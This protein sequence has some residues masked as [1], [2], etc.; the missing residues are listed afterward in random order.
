MNSHKINGY[1]IFENSWIVA[2]ATGFSRKSVN[3]K[4]GQMVQI[5]IL[6]RNIHPVEAIKL[7]KNKLVCGNCPLSPNNAIGADRCYVNV[8]QA[9]S[10]VW[11]AYRAGRYPKLTDYSVFDGFSV[12][13]GAYGDPCK[14]PLPILAS[15]ATHATRTTGYTHQWSNPVYSGYKAL[16]MASVDTPCQ[17]I[18]AVK[19]GW[20]TFRVAPLGSDWRMIDEISCP[21]S[22]EAGE[23][24]Q[25]EKC[26]LCCG[27]RKA[28]A[29]NVVIQRH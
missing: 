14:V 20:R 9:P 21:A 11:K 3:R 8:G 5:W 27:G 26:G 6:P 13:F 19:L 7:G 28:T 2:I 15:I 1:V 18:D 10:G 24:I 25:C 17:Q 4:T 22:K 23:R 12:R 16:L 29:K